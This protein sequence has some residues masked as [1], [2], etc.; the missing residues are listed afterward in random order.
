MIISDEQ[1]EPLIKENGLISDDALLDA[2]S[3]AQRE[4]LS[5]YEAILRMDLLSDRNLGELVA[6]F[7]NLPFV[8]LLDATISK[9]ILTMI[10]EV[11]ARKQRIIS[12]SKDTAGLHVAMA[13]PSDVEIINFLKKKT[14]LPIIVHAATEGDVQN[15]IALYSENLGDVFE[16]IIQENVGRVTGGK[17]GQA[18]DLPII[19]IVDTIISYAYQNKASDIH[20]EPQNEAS[21]TRFRIDGILHDV[22]TLP[23]EIHPQIVSRVKILSQ[24]RID[25][26]Q[27]AQDG[28]FQF[29]TSREKLDMR[30][31]I[32]PITNGEKVVMRLLSE[33]SRPFSLESLG[34]S[35]DNLSKVKDA[36]AKPYGM[37]LATGPTGSGKTTTIYAIL[38]ILNKRGVNISTIED[39]VEYE[40]EGV[41]QIQVNAKT[42]L[43]FSL[44]LRSIL[45]QDPDII[46][47]GEIRDEETA[48]IATGA[49]MTGH[50]VLST[51]HANDAASAIPRLIDMGV[52]PFLLAS[53]VNVII[54]QRLVRKIH[55]ACR[56]SQELAAADIKASVDPAVFARVF[57]AKETAD[58]SVYKGKGCKIDYGTGYEGRVGIFEMLVIND[59]IREAIMARKDAETIRKIA[60][61]TGMKTMMEDGLEKVAKGYTTVEELLRVTRE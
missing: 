3:L 52:E 19:K 21:I 61:T 17:N 8:S 53:T 40:I 55:D 29:E 4:K 38:K 32:M 54:A 48:G 15:A 43:T 34:F 23:Q 22:A 18:E 33:H 25:E 27:S 1:L 28:K 58:I 60:I 35:T 45:R 2:K 6:N 59:E 31:S 50:L 56:V 57:G 44:G 36:Y 37:I 16:K 10:P 11:V 49:A 24:L 9:E 39:P 26:H 51:I 14:G 47:V 20:I 42:N 7:L 5:L 30:V 46:L 12:F 41:N 13:D